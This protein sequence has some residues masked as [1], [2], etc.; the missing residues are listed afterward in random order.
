MSNDVLPQ[1]LVNRYKRKKNAHF[2]SNLGKQK[3][4]NLNQYY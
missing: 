3:F 4:Y 2:H 1:H